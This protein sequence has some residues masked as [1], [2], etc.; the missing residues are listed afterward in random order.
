MDRSALKLGLNRPSIAHMRAAVPL[1]LVQKEPL[2]P[3]PPA[4][5][6]I[7]GAAIAMWGNDTLG[8]CGLAAVANGDA[9]DAKIEGRAP[10]ATLSDVEQ[11]YYDVTGGQDTGVVLIDVLTKY[12]TQGLN[13]GGGSPSF[14]DAYV[15][16]PIEDIET[17]NSLIALFGFLYIGLALP[18]SAQQGPWDA[19][20]D[21]MGNNAPGSWGGHC[22]IEAAYDEQTRYLVTW[23]A[24]EP[25]AELFYQAYVRECWLYLDRRRAEMA[26][27]DY[28]KLLSIM[29]SVSGP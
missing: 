23:G 14:I 28:D 29:A 25:C 1:R 4:C 12:K 16:V 10:I 13:I 26:N 27:V 15:S 21:L 8:D 19:P 24:K 20:V 17:R 18:L 5:D 7:T 9:I 3:A 2:P 6:N 22:V 11:S